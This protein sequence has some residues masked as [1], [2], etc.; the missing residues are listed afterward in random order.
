[1][2]KIIESVFNSR[3]I[4]AFLILCSPLILSILMIMNGQNIGL[5]ELIAITVAGMF[6][7]YLQL[8]F[9]IYWMWFAVNSINEK[10]GLNLKQARKYKKMVRRTLI[11]T[12]I[13]ITMLI[14]NTVIP[15]YIEY[16]KTLSEIVKYLSYILI[17]VQLYLF[18]VW[19]YGFWIVTKTINTANESENNPERISMILFFLMPF[20]FGVIH[21]KMTTLIKST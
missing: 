8:F 5:P 20:T 7:P 3:P 14:V 17:V 6:Y 1:M 13:L 11:I 4:V 10:Y 12:M 16:N 15:Y 9:W 2:K 21:K 18:I 19:F